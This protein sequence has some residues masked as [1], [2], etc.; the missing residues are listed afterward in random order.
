MHSLKEG[1]KGASRQNRSKPMDRIRGNGSGKSVGRTV[2]ARPH[3][4]RLRRFCCCIFLCL[5]VVIASFSKG[6]PLR[7]FFKQEC[8]MIRDLKLEDFI[9]KLCK[10]DLQKPPCLHCSL[11]SLLLEKKLSACSAHG[12]ASDN[13]P[14]P[15]LSTS[16]CLSHTLILLLISRVFLL[17]C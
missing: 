6:N 2:G 15:A 11:H 9:E 17:H 10:W 16:G 1:K 7:V 14:E 12:L 3:P 5:F 4:V 8:V 13:P